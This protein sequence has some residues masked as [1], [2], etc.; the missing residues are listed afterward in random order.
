MLL[1]FARGAL[2]APSSYVLST[3]KVGSADLT[4]EE[5]R[6]RVEAR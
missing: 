1:F 3:Q 5:Y 4:E 2:N 6:F